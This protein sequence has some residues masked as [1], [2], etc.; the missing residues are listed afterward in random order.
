[1][2]SV[3]VP[4]VPPAVQLPGT[5]IPA[6]MTQQQAQ[7]VYKVRLGTP[8]PPSPRWSLRRVKS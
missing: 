2:T 6:N 1:M 3:Q 4:Q 8:F 5:A 7:E